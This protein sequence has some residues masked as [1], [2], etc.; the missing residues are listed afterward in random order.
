MQ[1]KIG[2]EQSIYVIVIIAKQKSG[3]AMKS[4]ALS[5]ILGV[6]DSYLKKIL[7]KLV[8]AG[9]LKSSASKTGGMSLGRQPQKITFLDIFEA[10]E[11]ETPFLHSHNL[12]ET[13][14]TDDIDEFVKQ[15]DKTLSIFREA[16]D[17]YKSSLSKYTI[18]D[19]LY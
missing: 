3:E 17:S 9:I 11:G 7:G 10:I 16:E 13:V 6:S 4:Q 15:A 12:R 8:R 14:Q 19:L 18:A 5:E 1:T 2:V